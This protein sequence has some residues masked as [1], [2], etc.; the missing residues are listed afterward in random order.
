MNIEKADAVSLRR[1]VLQRTN[2]TF[3]R[4]FLLFIL[5]DLLMIALCVAL[6]F[7]SVTLGLIL[8]VALLPRV[9]IGLA[10][11]AWRGS[12]MKLYTMISFHRSDAL[13]RFANSS[14]SPSLAAWIAWSYFAA[15]AVLFFAILVGIVV[16]VLSFGTGFLE[17]VGSLLSELFMLTTAIYLLAT[18]RLAYA[19]SVTGAVDKILNSQDELRRLYVVSA[20]SVHNQKIDQ[21]LQQK[22]RALFG[23]DVGFRFDAKRSTRNKTPDRKHN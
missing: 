15:L 14:Q 16:V 12:A 21:L 1:E 3:K 18:E 22:S 17:G 5:L 6:C 19:F 20:A 10:V 4:R 8:I 2:S 7:F 9:C 13:R 11:L 23:R